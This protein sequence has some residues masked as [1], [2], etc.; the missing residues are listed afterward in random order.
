MSPGVPI[1]PVLRREEMLE[2]PHFRARAVVNATGCW[3]DET[4]GT[5]S[6]GKPPK[7][8]KTKGGFDKALQTIRAMQELQKRI[9]FNFGISTTIFSM[10]L[11]DAEIATNQDT[12]NATDHRGADENT[13]AF[14]RLIWASRL[15]RTSQS[16]RMV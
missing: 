5:L 2:H 3:V 8:R 15:P 13:A 1:A 9:P 14:R 10:N 7:V 4:L 16:E 12:A 6:T 11:D